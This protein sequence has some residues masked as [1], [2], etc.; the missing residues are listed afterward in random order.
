MKIS[1][2]FPITLSC[3]VF[4]LA[5]CGGSGSTIK[6]TLGINR[7]SPD[8]FQVVSRPP[9]SVPPQF[10]L[11]PP[12]AISTSPTVVSA[13]MKAQSIVI[14]NEPRRNSFELD[15]IYSDTAV[16]PVSSRSLSGDDK[17]NSG[18][19]QNIGVSKADPDIR[20]K[21]IKQEIVTRQQKEESSWWD[22]FSYGTKKEKAVL[23]DADAERKRIEDNSKKNKSITEGE[24]PTVKEKDRG[25]LGDLFGW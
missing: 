2:I 1:S 19:L 23:V 25:L 16:M 3:S 18:F 20:E 8:E 13:D 5:S 6:E 7:T 10:N 12:S 11:R 22:I 21:L 24:T 9:L 14:G 4:F 15:E 17:A